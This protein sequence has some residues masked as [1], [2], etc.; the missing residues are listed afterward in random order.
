MSDK[1]LWGLYSGSS[2]ERFRYLPWLS[3]LQILAL[4]SGIFALNLSGDWYVMVRWGLAVMLFISALIP[5]GAT[6]MMKISLSRAYFAGST[7][8][9]ADGVPVSSTTTRGRS[10]WTSA[11]TGV[12]WK[13]WRVMYR[14]AFPALACPP[15][16]RMPSTAWISFAGSLCSPILASIFTSL[17]YWANPIF[18]GVSELS[19]ACM[20]RFRKDLKRKKPSR[21]SAEE[22]STRKS[23]STEQSK[24]RTGARKRGYS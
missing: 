17:P 12:L 4:S 20:K 23:T 10:S 5:S 8:G 24:L 13:P 21:V 14:R 6:P 9:S 19:T 18:T 16:Y 22:P 15:R 2:E 3:T 1:H 7:T 11:N